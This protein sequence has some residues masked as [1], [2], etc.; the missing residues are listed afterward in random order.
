M[1]NS[2]ESGNPQEKLFRPGSPLSRDDDGAC[3]NLLRSYD[4][5][6][7]YCNLLNKEVEVVAGHCVV[8]RKEQVLERL[9]EPF[10]IGGSV[11]IRRRPDGNHLT[12]RVLKLNLAVH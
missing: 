8:A 12:Q 2:R 10:D 3:S 11:E 5:L 9:L 1:G 4:L 7:G 6:A